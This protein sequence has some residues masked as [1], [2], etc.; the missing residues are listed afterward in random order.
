MPKAT[1]R[2]TVTTIEGKLPH[3]VMDTHN[4][5]EV[6]SAF[7]DSNAALAHVGHKNHIEAISCC[8]TSRTSNGWHHSTD[9]PNWVLTD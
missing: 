7:K 2:Y 8:P 4:A 3:A 5:N 6:I 9:C 1:K